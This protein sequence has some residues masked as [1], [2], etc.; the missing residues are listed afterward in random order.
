MLYIQN[1]I[2]IE[3]ENKNIAYNNLNETQ[4]PIIICIINF[5]KLIDFGC[6]GIFLAVLYW[7]LVIAYLTFLFVCIVYTKKNNK[8]F[9]MFTDLYPLMIILYYYKLEIFTT[10]ELLE[11]SITCLFV[12]Y[13][14]INNLYM[15]NR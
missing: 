12:T 3:T 7:L 1:E 14:F 11:T 6:T 2:I 9:F 13:I 5:I 8:H 4:S 15:R 10:T